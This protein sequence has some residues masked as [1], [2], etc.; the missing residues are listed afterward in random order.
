MRTRPI[1]PTE[2]R[3][4][5]QAAAP[6]AQV[7]IMIAAD[8]GLRISD[9]LRL[10][11]ADLR[12]RSLTVRERKT[13]KTR[14]VSL[15]PDTIRA[16]RAYHATH[17]LSRVIDRDRS[18]IYRQVR[19]AATSCGYRRVSMHSVRKL[20]ARQYARAHGLAATQREMQHDYLSTTLLYVLDDEQLHNLLTED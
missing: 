6:P 17:G 8:T 4:L 3:R 14:Q 5:I 12:R 18:T 7:C 10:T 20:Y 2:C 13:G 15:S 1:S 16:A 19:A 9:I 11:P